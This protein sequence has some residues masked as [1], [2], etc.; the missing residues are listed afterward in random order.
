VADAVESASDAVET[1]TT[2]VDTVPDAVETVGDAV[3]TVAD[4]CGKRAIIAEMA[5][6][7]SFS[8]AGAQ[9]TM[10]ATGLA[11]GFAMRT[12]AMGRRAGGRGRVPRKPKPCRIDVGFALRPG[13]TLPY[14]DV[15]TCVFIE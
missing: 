2:A 12:P 9:G 3:K 10:G 15:I 6:F 4:A 1:V 13:L 14:F 8:T 7:P 11:S 5:D